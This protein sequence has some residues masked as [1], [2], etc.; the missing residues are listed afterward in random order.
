LRTSPEKRR[1]E[2]KWPE[3]VVFQREKKL[4]PRRR[5]GGKGQQDFPER[6]FEEKKKEG[7][8]GKIGERQGPSSKDK[9][10]NRV[11]RTEK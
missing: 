4:A 5:Q 7:N 3:E 11:L 10:R 8:V 1:L 2:K 9:T 6:G